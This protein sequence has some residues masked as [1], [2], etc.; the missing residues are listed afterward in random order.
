MSEAKFKLT[1]VC[2]CGWSSD[3]P[4]AACSNCGQAICPRCGMHCLAVAA[5]PGESQAVLVK[6]VQAHVLDMAEHVLERASF[7]DEDERDGARH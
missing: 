3:Q 4:K 5:W 1:S 7:D 2:G 6:R